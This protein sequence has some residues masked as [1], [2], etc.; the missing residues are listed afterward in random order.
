MGTG[1]IMWFGVPIGTII[2]LIYLL[3]L[4]MGIITKAEGMGELVV[5]FYIYY[6]S[7]I[8]T[9]LS[10]IIGLSILLTHLVLG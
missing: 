3:L 5:V 4:K 9:I 7:G 10:L 1:I 8:L 6:F 2:Y